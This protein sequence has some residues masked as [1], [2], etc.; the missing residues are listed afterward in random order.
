MCIKLWIVF[1]LVI[2]LVF[3]L[4]LHAYAGADLGEGCG[5]RGAPPLPEMTCGFLI[6]L[7]SYKKKTMWYIGVEV[8]LETSTPPPRKNPRSASLTAVMKLLIV[9][10]WI[11]IVV[12]R[13]IIYVQLH[14][15]KTMN[16][17]LFFFLVL[18]AYGFNE[19]T[20]SWDMNIDSGLVNVL[21]FLDLIKAFDTVDHDIFFR[22][23]PHYRIPRFA[24][25]LGNG[26]QICHMDINSC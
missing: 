21:V 10:I 16:I 1:L 25:Y 11:L 15:Y 6:Q 23:L 26:T 9:G 3:F 12:F 7:V 14:L 19:A 22:K 17:N 2:N 13:R 20:D 8:E 24:Y 5:G 4:V 18:H